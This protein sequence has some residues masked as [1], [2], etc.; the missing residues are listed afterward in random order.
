MLELPAGARITRKATV[1][2]KK[3]ATFL[4]IQTIFDQKGKNSFVHKN[5]DLFHRQRISMWKI[6]KILGNQRKGLL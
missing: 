6:G 2:T 4:L 3:I 5:I 1:C